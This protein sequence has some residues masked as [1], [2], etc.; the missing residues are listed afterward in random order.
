MRERLLQAFRIE[1]RDYIEGIGAFLDAAEREGTVAARALDEMFRQAHSLKGAARAVGLP[2]VETVAHRVETLF[3]RIRTVGGALDAAAV[4]LVRRALD[5]VEDE[6]ASL[7][8]SAPPPDTAPLLA[9]LDAHL[10]EAAPVPARPAEA[11]AS[12]DAPDIAPV[13]LPDTAPAGPAAPEPVAPPQPLAETMRVEVAR[14][15]R[16]METAGELVAGQHQRDEAVR[17]LADLGRQIGELR[18]GWGKLRRG[19]RARDG[20]GGELDPLLDQIE[21]RLRGVARLQRSVHGQERRAAR[22]ARQLGEDL[23]RELG[24]ARMVPVEVAFGTVRPM[25]R[26]LAAD[27]GVPVEVQATGLELRADRLVLQRLKD[28]VLH[29]L[30][31][32]VGHGIEPAAERAARGKPPAGAVSLAFAV[33]QGRLTVTVTDD[34]RGIDAARLRS[35]ARRLRL[36]GDEVEAMGDTELLQLVFRPGFTTREE[37]SDLS[38]RG[39]GLSVVWEAATRLGGAVSVRSRAGAGTEFRLSVPVTAMA[40]ALLLVRAG[41][42]LYGIPAGGI[43]RL[44][45]AGPA[46]IGTVEGRLVLRIGDRPVPLASLA[47]ALGAGDGE[48]QMG[49]QRSVPVVVVGGEERLLAVACDE[50]LG[51]RQGLVRDLGHPLP[52]SGL[53]SG[54]VLLED[55]AMALVINPFVLAGGAGAGSG[56]ELVE[57]RPEPTTPAILVVD[58]S[59]T[60][61]TLEKSIL[62]AHGFEVHLAVNGMQAL[63]HLRAERID[64]VIADVQ[65]PELD[66]FGLLA[67]M[68]EDPA[69]ADIP[70]ILVTSLEKRE[71]RARGLALGAD[72]YIVKRKFDQAELLSTIGQLL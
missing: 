11:P 13:A 8:G 25:V 72:A 2:A 65:M 56:L 19:L 55:G 33:D 28:P 10:G 52:P 43:E 37:V 70:V 12:N 6:V 53:V 31:N 46:D 3:D 14:F 35:A 29:L 67:S 27:L 50:L 36:A 34:G 41:D 18:A 68:K 42:Q 71:D 58:D 49:G 15:D 54:G 23:Q 64:L 4:A 9:A 32:A 20:A 61:R 69:L 22:T 5:A 21:Q 45:R 47:G 24:D 44:H 38:G 66:G 16:I 26:A 7:D 40:Q 57:R 59:L 17:A 39:M 63:R 51:L 62:E 1:H 60:T 48:I 30:R